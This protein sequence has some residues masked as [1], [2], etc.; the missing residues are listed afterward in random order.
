MHTHKALL[1]TVSGFDSHIGDAQRTAPLLSKNG[2]SRIEETQGGGICMLLI[3]RQ[4]MR[5]T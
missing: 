5:T 3:M 1:S 2:V 4:R